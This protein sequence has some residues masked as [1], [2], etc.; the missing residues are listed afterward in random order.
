MNSLFRAWKTITPRRLFLVDGLGAVLSASSLGLFLP[1]FE[2]TVGLP[3]R[4]L[5][6][7]AVLASGLAAGSLWNCWHNPRDWR[8]WLKGIA[9]ANLVY[10]GLT[11]V[12]LLGYHL[13]LTVWG[14]AYFGLELAVIVLLARWELHTAVRPSS[15]PD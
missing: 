3:T 14:G 4:V 1:A 10:G 12:L 2:R 9:W 13:T 6:A 11:V 5:Y 7:L 15:P 8:T